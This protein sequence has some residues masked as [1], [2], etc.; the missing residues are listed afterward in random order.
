[1]FDLSPQSA[2]K[3]T[4]SRHRRMTEFPDVPRN[5]GLALI[6][7]SIESSFLLDVAHEGLAFCDRSC[8]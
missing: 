2:P 5:I 7:Q 3:R 4:L 8:A 6:Y 1:M